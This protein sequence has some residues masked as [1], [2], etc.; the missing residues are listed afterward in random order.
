[1]V[2]EELVV[3]EK[4]DVR[5]VKGE[6]EGQSLKE[7]KERNIVCIVVQMLYMDQLQFVIYK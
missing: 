6:G 2:V 4:V 7:E 1:M 3:K 5:G